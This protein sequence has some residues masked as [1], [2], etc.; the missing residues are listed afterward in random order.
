MHDSM[1]KKEN[2]SKDVGK[3]R[4]KYKCMLDMKKQQKKRESNSEKN[5]KTKRGERERERNGPSFSHAGEPYLDIGFENALAKSHMLHA[6]KPKC[7]CI[8]G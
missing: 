6:Y 2:R 1:E 4:S 5:T 7:I 8:V 3:G